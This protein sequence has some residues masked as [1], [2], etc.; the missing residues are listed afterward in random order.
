MKF[1]G[2][3]RAA[4]LVAVV[5]GAAGSVGFM[6][7]AGR[8]NPSRLLILGFLIW[9]LSPFVGLLWADIVSNR[10][11][12]VPRATLYGVMLILTLVSLAIYGNVAFGPPRPQAAFSFI[13][14]PAASW[15][16]IAIAVAIGLVNS[17]RQSRIR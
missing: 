4:A 5:A 3:L 15:L 2:V 1:L 13:V 6:L 11:S 17:R 12:V 16:A 8:R 10:W 9:V 7:R 14:V